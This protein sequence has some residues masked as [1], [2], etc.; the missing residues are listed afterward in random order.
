MKNY[1]AMNQL[2]LK[3]MA[4]DKDFEVSYPHLFGVLHRRD[5]AA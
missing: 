3:T 2:A 1:S 4:G 5:M